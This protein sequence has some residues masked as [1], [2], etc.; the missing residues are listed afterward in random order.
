MIKSIIRILITWPK[1]DLI[2]LDYSAIEEAHISTHVKYI[3][4]C[5]STL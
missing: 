5:A 2:A 1:W 3:N 4:T